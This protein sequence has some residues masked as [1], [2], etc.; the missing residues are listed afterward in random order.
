[1]RSSSY[2]PTESHANHAAMMAHLGKIFE[3]HQENG[4][5]R[6]DYFARVYYGN[7]PVSTP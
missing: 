1:L 7:L 6:M 3:Q 2:A 4:S 5:V